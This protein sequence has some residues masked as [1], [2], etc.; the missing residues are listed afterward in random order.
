MSSNTRRAGVSF[1]IIAQKNWLATFKEMLA[2]ADA[3]GSRGIDLFGIQAVAGLGVGAKLVPEL[4]ELH[5][6]GDAEPEAICAV[7]ETGVRRRIHSVRWL[8]A[9]AG[10]IA[11][12]L[13]HL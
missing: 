3:C 10:P 13:R 6:L 8:L 9:G 12:V 2:G 11:G 4:A 1:S 5:A 7:R